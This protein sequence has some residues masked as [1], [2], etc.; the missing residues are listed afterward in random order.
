MIDE[1]LEKGPRTYRFKFCSIKMVYLEY[2]FNEV[3]H[4]VEVEVK[5]DTLVVPKTS[6]ILGS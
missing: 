3:K 4:K 2:M 1:N 6:S 5:I